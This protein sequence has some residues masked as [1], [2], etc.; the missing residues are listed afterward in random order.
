MSQ[1]FFGHPES[2]LFGAYHAPKGN[3]SSPRAVILCPSIGHEFIRSHWTLRLLG[4]QLARKGVHVLRFDYH[5]IGD[6]AGTV[7][8]VDSIEIWQRNVKQAIDHLKHAARVEN[9]ML[10]GHRFGGLLASQVATERPDVNSLVLWEPVVSGSDYLRA[11]RKMHDTMLDLWTCKMT[12]PDNHAQEEILGSLYH[13]TL[14]R[15]IES[16]DFDLRS[17]IQPQLIVEPADS[18][19]QFTCSEPSL[20]KVVRD[21]RN[22][23]W[24]DLRELETAYLRPTTCRLIVKNVISM[25][26]RLNQFGM[27]RQIKM[28]AS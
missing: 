27:I 15:E 10:I 12:T 17:V 13:R 6:S 18:K 1:R 4:N 3:D 16:I 7:E 25:F 9:V 21:D 2:P 22:S 26:D 19:R 20:Q 14:I 28:G 8:N 23:T 5:G 24:T 11:L